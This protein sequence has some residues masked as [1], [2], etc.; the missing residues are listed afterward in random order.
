VVRLCGSP[1]H[2]EGLAWAY[3]CGSKCSIL[4]INAHGPVSLGLAVRCLA[5]DI[6]CVDGGTTLR[7][8]ISFRV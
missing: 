4:P 2:S 3:R 8:A 6:L 1:K 7:F 5:D